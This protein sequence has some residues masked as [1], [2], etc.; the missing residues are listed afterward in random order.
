[1]H[2]DHDAARTAFLQAL[3]R[4]IAVAS[5]LNDADMQAA[6]YCRGW[7]VGDVLAHLH[8]GLQEMLLG[9]VSR[10][11]APP[12]TDAASYWRSDP[13]SNDDGVHDDIA[14]IRF[15]RLLA[16]AYRRPTGLI[17]HMRPTAD[18]LRRAVTDLPDGAVTFQQRV[19]TTG[20]FLATWVF[21][22]A[23][24][25][26]DLTRELDVPPPPD[27]ALE[28]SRATVEALAGTP[29]PPSWSDRTAVLVGSGRVAMTDEQRSGA[30]SVA[31]KL[32][33]L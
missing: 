24:H 15:T 29:L 17:G 14:Q 30:G 27:A 11:D 18:G 1:M 22:V 13:P 33:V 19:L 2:V 6:S 25:H 9:V 20:D 5:D 32:P 26:L 7:T 31:E 23:V 12:D 4:L 28:L 16:A 3:D 8:M 21:E 10:T